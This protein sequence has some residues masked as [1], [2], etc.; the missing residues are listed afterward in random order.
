MEAALLST[1][2]PALLSEKEVDRVL[3]S[4]ISQQ[5]TKVVDPK[6]A[7][8]QVLKAFYSKVDKSLVDGQLVKQRA[9]ALLSAVS[10]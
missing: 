5:D 3:E 6:R 7:A 10:P 1:F 9:D 2:L 8:G 4:V